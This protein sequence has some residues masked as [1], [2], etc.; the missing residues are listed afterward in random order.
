MTEEDSVREQNQDNRLNEGRMLC[1]HSRSDGMRKPER[2]ELKLQSFLD[3]NDQ[4]QGKTG[5]DGYEGSGRSFTMKNA[6]WN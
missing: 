5:S 6:L 2:G 3:G 4:Q 1:N